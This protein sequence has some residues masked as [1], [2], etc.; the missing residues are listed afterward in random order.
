[1]IGG[2][3]GLVLTHAIAKIFM[4][5]WDRR[6]KEEAEKRG[7]RIVLYK[8]CGNLIAGMDLKNERDDRGSI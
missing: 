3:I 4:T 6:F 7:L 2:P 1:M 5:W 8:R